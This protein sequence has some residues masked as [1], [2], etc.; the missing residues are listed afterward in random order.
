MAETLIRRMTLPAVDTIKDRLFGGFATSPS[1]EDEYAV[2]VYC[3]RDELESILD[4]LGF[5]SSLL[6]ALKISLY[7]NVEDG[8]WVRRESV[9]ADEQL[10]VVSHERGDSAAIDLYAHQ[11][12]SKITHPVKH[13]RKVDYDAE[14]GV[15]RFRDA[16]D[17]YRQRVDDPPKCEIQPPRHRPWAWALH[18]LSFVSTPAAARL[19]RTLDDF[20]ARVRSRL[21]GKG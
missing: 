19:G 18:L 4:E 1:T 8:S 15:T 9:L 6:S 5:S 7:G 21:T 2:T 13:Y 16:L 3:P 20:E 17:D 11:E 10:H 14:A 12:L